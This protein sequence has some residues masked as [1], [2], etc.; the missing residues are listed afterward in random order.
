M[1]TS[2]T[3]SLLRSDRWRDYE[4][5]DSGEGCKLE[6]FG[7]HVFVRPEVQAMW[8]RSLPPKDWESVDAVFLPSNEESGGHWQFKRKEVERW[9]MAYQLPGSGSLQ[10]WAMTTPGR[11]LGV[12]PE[13][14][15]HWD[16][17]T[18][19]I[20]RASSTR[21][22]PPSVLNLFGYTGLATLAAAASGAHVTHLDASRKSVAWAAR[23]PGAFPS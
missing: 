7:S 17:I 16:F 14:A 9:K 22:A 19:L 23:K 1:D 2:P 11:H 21:P 5:I 10:F 13:A 6:R 4:L 20:Q 8:S 15:P 3:F 12:F 18:E